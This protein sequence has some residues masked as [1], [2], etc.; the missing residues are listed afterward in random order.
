MVPPTR[1]RCSSHDELTRSMSIRSVVVLIPI[2]V[3]FLLNHDLAITNGETMN[4]FIRLLDDSGLKLNRR[5]FFSRTSLG[6]GGAALASLLSEHGAAG[7]DRGTTPDTR[8]PTPRGDRSGRGGN[9]LGLSLPAQGQ[10]GDL[11]VHERRAVAARSLRLQA[12]P[13]QDER[14]GP[15]RVGPDG[16]AAH[17]DVVEPGDVAD[18]GLD[19]SFCTPRQ[20]GC[21]DQRSPAVHRTRGRRALHHQLGLHR[22]DQSRPGDHL[23][24]DR[25]DDR[26]PAFDRDPG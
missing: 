25:L 9:P 1:R 2:L 11:P 23:L 14:P 3:Q 6:L 4:E 15:A 8:K 12:A 10:A 19:L 20:V 13:Q 22:G 16:A 26:R 5:H 17:V 18:G 7:T 24:P 21:V